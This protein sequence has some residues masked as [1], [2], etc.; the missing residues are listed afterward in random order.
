[1]RDV[2]ASL[3]PFQRH[4]TGYWSALTRTQVMAIVD[5][6]ASVHANFYCDP[7]LRDPS[8]GLCTP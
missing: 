7:Q 4:P 6:L 3:R 1:M 8:L 2:S 5:A